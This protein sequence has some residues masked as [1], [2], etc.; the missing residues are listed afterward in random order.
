MLELLMTRQSELDRKVIANC[1]GLSFIVLDELHTYRGRQGADVAMLI[2][3][4][5][6]RLE[7]STRP[8]QCIGTSATMATEGTRES[9]DVAV[10]QVAS[11]LFGAEISADSLITETL[12]R[13]TDD[14]RSAEHVRGEL[15]PAI[16]AGTPETLSNDDLKR[17]PLAIWV[18]TRL[19]LR[20]ADGGAW[21]R[22]KPLR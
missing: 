3:R 22:A 1:A 19:G 4:V 5:R 8:M 16:D 9:K 18:E 2:R 17:H 10:A 13:V 6:E 7:D 11:R 14:R 15:G 12:L 20:A 21:E